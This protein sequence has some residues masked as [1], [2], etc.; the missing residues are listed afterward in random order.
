MTTLFANPYDLSATGFYFD[1]TQDYHEKAGK[2]RNAYGDPVE[3][4]EIEFID[5]DM[6]DAQLGK[7]WGL[8]QNNIGAF[9]DACDEWDEHKKRCFIIA[10]GECG[11]SFDPEKD[12]S[13]QFDV[14]IYE[15]DTM[16]DLAQE[17]VDEG[18]YGEIPA[19]LQFYIDYDA[20]ARDLSVDF[21][22]IEID[23]C[24]LIYACR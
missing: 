17:F 21:S 6:I 5:G 4:F 14:D 8:Y 22:K 2:K 18:H 20:I 16:R 12:D 3:E 23:S 7:A 24:H 13:D 11:Y 9:L 10:V 1:S 15:C 19:H